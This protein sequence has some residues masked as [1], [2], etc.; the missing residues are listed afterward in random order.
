MQQ[1]KGHKDAEAAVSFSYEKLADP[2]NKSSI[3]V[4]IQSL[5]AIKTTSE[6]VVFLSLLVDGPP[7][8]IS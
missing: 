6:Q 1:R 8:E 3:I 5:S 7:S 2:I 4:L